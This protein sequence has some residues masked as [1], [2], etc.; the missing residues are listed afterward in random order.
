MG[1]KVTIKNSLK[2]IKGFTIPTRPVMMLEAIKAQNTFVQNPKEVAATILQDMALAATVL[3]TANTL[4]AGYNRKVDSIECA[5]VLLGQEKLRKVT[6]E[7]FMSATITGK[8]SLVQKVRHQAVRT[9][10]VLAWLSQEMATCSPNFKN[11]T[12]PIVAADE[13]YVVGLFHDCGQLVL[14]NRFPDYPNLIAERD[15]ATETLEEVEMEHYRTNHALLGS[16]LCHAWQLPKP[17]TQVIEAHHHI[18]AFAAGKPVKARKFAVIHALLFLAEWIE[19]EILDWEW[20]RGQDYFYQF[21][22]VDA[23]QVSQLRQRARELFPPLENN[24]LEN[25]NVL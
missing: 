15:K 23:F 19:E 16:L 25:N 14:L 13:A 5:I 18:E 1:N 24:T 7:L 21:F 8:D 17:L 22:D 12:L 2:L 4:L 3:Q 11:E 10:K 9:A 6:Q 20:A